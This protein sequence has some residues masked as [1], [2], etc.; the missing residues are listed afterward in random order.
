MGGT[1][2]QVVIF[3]LGESAVERPL[4]VIKSD[5]VTEKEGFA[6][7]GHSALDARAGDVKLPAGFQPRCV[8]Q[9]R[10]VTSDK[11]LAKKYVR[12]RVR[13][14]CGM[15]PRKF[16]ATSFPMISTCG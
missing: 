13:A 1:A 8:L 14:F 16:L 7:K 9:V 4:Q 10:Y 12:A 3:E 15:K 5:L 2:G 11:R 6:W